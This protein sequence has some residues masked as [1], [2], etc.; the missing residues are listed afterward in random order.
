LSR[1]DFFFFRYYFG[2][3]LIRRFGQGVLFAYSLP[4]IEPGTF[5]L[6]FPQLVIR[7][8]K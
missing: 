6:R 2:W 4:V 8:L 7:P 3:V 5:T 1:K